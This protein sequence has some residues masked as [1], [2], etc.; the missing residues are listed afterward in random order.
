MISI[1]KTRLF[2]NFYGLPLFFFPLSTAASG[3]A[4]GV[5]LLV[6]GL[7]G[8]W[9]NWRAIRKRGWW[10]PWLLLMAWTAIGLLWTT[11]LFFGQKVLVSTFDAIFAFIGATLPWQERW[12]KWVIR[13]FLAGILVNEM[14]AFLMT[15]KVLPWHNTDWIPYT[16]FCDHI[17]LSLVIAHAIL[18]LIYDQKMQWNFPRSVNLMLIMVLLAQMAL[19]P[20]RSGQVLLILLLPM[21]LFMLYPGRW[22]LALPLAGLFAAAI[23]LAVPDVRQHLMVGVHELMTFSP[24]QADVRTSWGIRVVAMWGGAL[25]FWQHPFFG[26]GTGD[27]YPA[28]LQLQAQHLLPATPGF[29]MNTAANSFLS[30]AASLG[31]VGLSLFIWVLWAIGREA[32]QAR[33]TPQG[34]FVLSYFAIYVIG[35]TFDSLSWGYA[36]AVNIALFAGMPLLLRWPL[37]SR[38]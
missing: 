7:S 27:F 32:G 13:W 21:A 29:I 26:V 10:L 24:S 6:Y 19:T 22:R 16:G 30:E 3:I 9:R 38:R 35:G 4:M 12:V 28:V 17:F 5:L 31:V 20:G 18:W 33:F 11:N 2:P 14:L 34:W 37:V 1:L 8:Y 25:L 36:D 15:W 23:L